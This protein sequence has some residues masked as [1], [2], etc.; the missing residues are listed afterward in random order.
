[1]ARRAPGQ[2]SIFPYRGA[3]ACALVLS[4]GRR[5]TRTA[6]T[7][8]AAARLLEQLKRDQ[9]AAKAPTITVAEFAAAWLAEK[10]LTLRP[11][12]WVR[13]EE[14]VRL[15]LLPTL[16]K[17]RLAD[18]T[19][20]HLGALYAAKVAAGLSRQ[21]VRHLHVTLKGMLRQAVLAGALTQ[22]PADR[23]PVPRVERAP[24]RAFTADQATRFLAGVGGDRLAAL[25]LLLIYTG[26]REG[27]LFALQW[28]D[29]DLERGLIRIQ[30][31]AR[32]VK[33]AGMVVG[34][35]KSRS[36]RRALPLTEPAVAALREQ[37]AR[38]LPGPWVFPSRAGTPLR[39]N[40][41]L[42]RDYY[43]LLDRLDVPRLR[44]H[45]LRHT[46]ATLLMALGEHPGVVQHLLG[47][48][49]I[50]VTI[51]TYSHTSAA[52]GRAAVERLTALLR[53]PLAGDA[54]HG[55]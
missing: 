41:W 18:L 46:F 33:G 52:M 45:E 26:A 2:G 28:G 7:E 6:P 50:D 25:Y 5:I 30:R 13:Y 16:G 43:P 22:N 35:P 51:D 36:G 42:R 19:P 44:P 47:H 54:S 53:A 12:T 31:T 40:N 37:R 32:P 27:E 21:T 15:H 39:A 34:E 11:G 20:A 3:W 38:E 1:M 9:P 29:V 48:S 10:R 49:S 8:R 4:D 14:Y 55:P 23:A 17:R 24:R